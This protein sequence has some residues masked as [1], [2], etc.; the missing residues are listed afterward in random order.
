MKLPNKYIAID[1]ETTDADYRR[2]EIIQIGAVI[3]NEDLSL[4]EKFSTYLHPSSGFRNPEA[5]AINKISEETLKQAPEA[6]EALSC[7]ESFALDVD[8]RP[9]LAAW[10]TYFD[11]V[12]LKEF[13]R[14]V[15]R[16]YPFSYRCLDL[17]SIA[18]WEAAKKGDSYSGGVSGFL[19]R[20][21]LTFEGNPHDG[22][23]DIINTMKIIQHYGENGR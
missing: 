23:D 17:K 7:F 20:N 4:G 11:V 14:Q 1:I 22:L 9:L 18:I 15:G 19:E 2:G 16:K 6:D 3:I 10:G 8:R 13:Y 12:F 5:M 21:G